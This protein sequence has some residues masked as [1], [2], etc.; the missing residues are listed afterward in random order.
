LRPLDKITDLAW[1]PT[2]STPREVEIKKLADGKEIMEH[3]KVQSLQNCS[4]CHR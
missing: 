2:A 4:T 1:Q 3:W